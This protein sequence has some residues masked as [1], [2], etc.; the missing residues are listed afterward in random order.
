MENDM[1][2]SNENEVFESIDTLLEVNDGLVCDAIITL[3]YNKNYITESEC[4][5]L[6]NRLASSGP[7]F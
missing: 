1:K 4:T 2:Q 3:F 5:N 7:L 6:R